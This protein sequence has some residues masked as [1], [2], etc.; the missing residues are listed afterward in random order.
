MDDIDQHVELIF[1]GLYTLY[2]LP[3]VE[4]KNYVTIDK[5][6]FLDQSVK[7][8][9]R[10]YDSIRKIAIGQGHDYTTGCLLDCNYLKNY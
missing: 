10:T 6:N 4:I 7:N 9:S 1:P 5:Q 2:Y 3:T 8:N